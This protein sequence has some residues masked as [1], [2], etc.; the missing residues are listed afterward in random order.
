MTNYLPSQLAGKG[1]LALADLTAIGLTTTDVD[2]LVGWRNYATAQ[3]ASGSFGSYN[4]NGDANASTN[5]YSYV[6][7]TTNGFLVVNPQQF[8][9]RTDQAF[10]SRQALLKYQRAANF[11]QDALQYLGTFSRDLEQPSFYP[12]SGRPRNTRSPDADASSNNR[13]GGGNDAVDPTTFTQNQDLINPSL[14]TAR[15][16]AGQPVMKR[17]FP[18]SRLS[19]LEQA[20]ATLRAGGTPSS[21]VASQIYIY[22]GLTWDATNSRWIYWHE[23]AL[24]SH[25]AT[26]PS[27]KILKLS[28]IAALNVPT[29]EP[30]FFETLKAVINCD[31]LGKQNAG[32]DG[33]TSPHNVGGIDCSI[34]YQVIQIG[35][36]LADQY[37]ADSYPTHIAFDAPPSPGATHD[38]YGTENLPYLAGWTSSWFRA[39]QL[40]S[41][42]IM[43]NTST[44]TFQPPT[45]SPG[46]NGFPFETWVFLH[47]IIWNP[48]APDSRSSPPNVPTNFRVVAGGGGKGA[49]ALTVHPVVFPPWWTTVTGGV[50]ALT[51][52]QHSYPATGGFTTSTFSDAT[53]DPTLDFITF[54]TGASPADFREPYCLRTQNFPSGSTAD[55]SYAAGKPSTSSWVD[56]TLL[57]VDA[58]SQMIGFFCG[59]AWTGPSCATAPSTDLRTGD[60][61]NCL[62]QGSITSITSG[63]TDMQFLLQYQMGN[64]WYTY[65]MI[66]DVYVSAGNSSSVD[67]DD[68]NS[69]V[70]RGFRACFR[71]DAR[72][73][74]WGLPELN[75]FPI[76]SIPSSFTT[77]NSDGLSTPTP[78]VPWPQGTTINPSSSYAYR[79]TTS[80][81]GISAPGWKWTLG[82]SNFPLLN[83]DVSDLAVN[84]FN[85]TVNPNVSGTPTTTA[86]PGG[87]F[88]YTDPDGVIRRAEGAY[89]SGNDGLPLYTGNTNSRPVILNRPFESVA[90][91]GYAFS[92][93]PWRSVDF[94]TPESGYSALLDAF[95]LNDLQNAP[96]D[97]TVEGRVNLNTRQPKVLQ[98]LIQGVSKAEGGVMSPTGTEGPPLPRRLSSPGRRPIQRWPATRPAASSTRA[99]CA[100]S[101]SW[102]ASMSRR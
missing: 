72:T 18:L 10:S 92:G 73:D 77:A 96:S 20:G 56:T 70:S 79:M 1:S 19:L 83:L 40:A 61:T 6:S 17:R 81:S 13:N 14:L 52:G 93:I 71:V 2:N 11:S 44:G 12:D 63:I 85:N 48:H 21:S 43:A 51:G 16:V 46:K 22:F 100:I 34:N 30:D 4:F 87:K 78:N 3:P 88:Y 49:L 97:V 27:Q 15:D 31:S 53:I 74:R 50:P 69:A 33:N 54:S 35:A 94:F 91:M 29:R 84:V 57:N 80:S 65:D 28:D 82:S 75:I 66:N 41:G 24:T 37:D 55:I 9:N 86:S 39:R 99:R 98:A 47:P 5:Y 102:S 32:W 67:V 64:S 60:V 76:G 62:A 38:F 95:C 59:K 90:E 101:P 68:T 7:T 25:S 42:D 89:F 26:T 45:V 58:G 36:N 8:N 23:D